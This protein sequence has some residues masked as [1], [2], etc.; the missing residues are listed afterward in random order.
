MHYYEL[1]KSTN[2]GRSPYGIYIMAE[3]A[4]GATS[5]S[6]ELEHATSRERAA[7]DRWHL[8]SWSTVKKLFIITNNK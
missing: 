6:L 3:E 2:G 8:P 4:I 5:R 7:D 1:K